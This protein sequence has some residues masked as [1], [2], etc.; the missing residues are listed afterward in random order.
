MP[1]SKVRGDALPEYTHYRDNGCDA[2]PS[3][4]TCPLTRCRYDIA[5][6]LRTLLNVDRDRRIRELHLRGATA[7]DLARQFGVSRRNIFRIFQQEVRYE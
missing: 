7:T 2:H 6:G 4:L 1:T 5:R 3:C